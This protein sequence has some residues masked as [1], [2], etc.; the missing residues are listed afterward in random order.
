M[1]CY[2]SGSGAGPPAL[3]RDD[4]SLHTSCHPAEHLARENGALAALSTGLL[5]L[6]MSEL[7]DGSLD[8]VRA[9]FAERA[10]IMAAA[11]RPS[12]VG[13]LVVL[14]WRGRETEARTEAAAVTRYAT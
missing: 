12:D 6:A 7:L 1:R 11:G 4:T 8:A 14:A 5:F 10:E 13:E 2:G 9:R 3:G